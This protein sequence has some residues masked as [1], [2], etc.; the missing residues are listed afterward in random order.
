MLIPSIRLNPTALPTTLPF[1]KVGVSLASPTV[2]WYIPNRIYN[3]NYYTTDVSTVTVPL[4]LLHS[5]DDT[6]LFVEDKV[7]VS[8]D[9]ADIVLAPVSSIMLL[10]ISS[11]EMEVYKNIGGMWEL[12]TSVMLTV[13]TILEER[14]LP[15]CLTNPSVISYELVMDCRASNNLQDGQIVR[16]GEYTYVIPLVGYAGTQVATLDVSSISL[17][18]MDTIDRIFITNTIDVDMFPYSSAGRYITIHVFPIASSPY[19]VVYYGP[20]YTQSS[21]AIPLVNVISPSTPLSAENCISAPL[22]HALEVTG[23]VGESTQYDLISVPYHRSRATGLIDITFNLDCTVPDGNP[24]VVVAI[25]EDTVSTHVDYPGLPAH[26]DAVNLVLDFAAEEMRVTMAADTAVN[27]CSAGCSYANTTLTGEWRVVI[28]PLETG[29]MLSVYHEGNHVDSVMLSVL[30]NLASLKPLY[31]TSYLNSALP[32]IAELSFVQQTNQVPMVTDKD[33]CSTVNLAG[34]VTPCMDD[35]TLASAIG[36]EDHIDFESMTV[37]PLAQ[38]DPIP[39]ISG[40][41]TWA[42]S[43]NTSPCQIADNAMLENSANE[44]YL[45]SNSFLLGEAPSSATLV[46]AFSARWYIRFSAIIA[47]RIF[48]VKYTPTLLT[49]PILSISIDILSTGWRVRTNVVGQTTGAVQYS[50]HANTAPIPEANVIYCVGISIVKNEI[51]LYINGVGY[52]CQMNLSLQDRMFNPSAVPKEKFTISLSSPSHCFIDAY[53]S[54]FEQWTGAEMF[55]LNNDSSTRVTTVDCDYTKL[56][57]DISKLP[58]TSVVTV[59]GY[60]GSIISTQS[61]AVVVTSTNIVQVY[62][63]P[64]NYGAGL[65]DLCIT[66]ASPTQVDVMYGTNAANV[67]ERLDIASTTMVRAMRISRGMGIFIKSTGQ[68]TVR[69]TALLM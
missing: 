62:S 40:G 11:T 43:N 66:P 22:V 44:L 61:R 58:L 13:S 28:L 41:F 48:E 26:P 8:K 34:T 29:C 3:G 30:S 7:F 57:T 21:A 17:L 42:I 12:V 31:I 53:L 64:D 56:T 25:H 19:A 59:T 39:S 38:L 24:Y 32:A 10:Y 23:G 52:P 9:A 2:R 46:D 4:A 35:I 50:I 33:M 45:T 20:N 37:G 5:V 6:M 55:A 14:V 47:G 63:L 51:I 67:Y 18:D 60:G 15:I 49:S 16:T 69:I 1:N 68:V 54:A 36:V 27:L 65:I